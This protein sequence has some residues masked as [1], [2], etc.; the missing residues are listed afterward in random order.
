MSITNFKRKRDY[1][2]L[3]VVQMLMVTR[4]IHTYIH[5][6]SNIE[7]KKTDTMLEGQQG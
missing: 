1:T 7:K 4:Y 5:L 2:L 6:F 3:V